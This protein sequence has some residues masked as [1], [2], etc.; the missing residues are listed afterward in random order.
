M[1]VFNYRADIALQWHMEKSFFIHVAKILLISVI[2]RIPT[3][4]SMWSLFSYKSYAVIVHG[5]IS[6]C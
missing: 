3:E 5:L 6:I 4:N 1:Q 2:S